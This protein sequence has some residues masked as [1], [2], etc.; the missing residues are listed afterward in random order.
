MRKNV[1]LARES[2]ARMD[3]IGQWVGWG[4]VWPDAHLGLGKPSGNVGRLA[5]LVRFQAWRELLFVMAMIHLTRPQ[6]RRGRALH[7]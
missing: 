5:G 4:P 1:G 7:H 6:T 3:I 2:Q